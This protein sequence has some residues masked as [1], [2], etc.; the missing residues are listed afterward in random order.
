MG[1]CVPP[2]GDQCCLCQQGPGMIAYPVLVDSFVF[3]CVHCFIGVLQTKEWHP[4]AYL[5]VQCGVDQGSED[6]LR[7]IHDALSAKNGRYP[8]KQVCQPCRDDWWARVQIA[9]MNQQEAA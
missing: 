2:V 6:R 7:Q 8:I 3:V 4:V 1:E 9:L 5:C